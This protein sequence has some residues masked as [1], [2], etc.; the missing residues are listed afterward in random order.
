MSYHEDMAKGR[1]PKIDMPPEAIDVSEKPKM[2]LHPELQQTVAH[3]AQEVEQPEEEVV[4]N[5]IQNEE[6]V[7]KNP[8]PVESEKEKNIRNL[9]LKAER[10][11][12][13]ER[14]R[15][16]L[17]R[18]LNEIENR[19]T[20]QVQPQQVEEEDINIGK[21]DI[22]EGKHLSKYDRKIKDMQAKLDQYKQ[23]TDLT[24]TE[25]RL[26]NQYPDFDKVVSKDNIEMLRSTYPEIAE[27]LNNSSIDIYS[28]AVSAYTLIKRLGISPED[29]YQEDKMKA[30]KNSAKPRPLTSINPQ[31][32]D[33]PL[34]RANAFSNG[35]TDDL[36][37]QLRKEMADAIKYR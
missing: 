34:S 37:A 17:L 32:G 16:E 1:K 5:P 4:E 21:D 31:Q 24:A 33:T 7:A 20:Q 15:D 25:T 10:A 30:Q 12:R 36:K 13:A 29:V 19:K 14:E 27:T 18:R 23:Q 26:K 11:E 3:E 8:T 2:E 35:L 9:R 28:K 6:V 22:V